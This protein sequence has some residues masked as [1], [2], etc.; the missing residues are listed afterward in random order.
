MDTFS[1]W[2]VTPKKYSVTVNT[3]GM[4]EHPKSNQ[5]LRVI[6]GYKQDISIIVPITI[7]R[8]DF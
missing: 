8:F 3:G 5:L 4:I 7:R 6:V 1:F 2:H